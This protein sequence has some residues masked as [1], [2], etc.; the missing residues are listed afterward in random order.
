[1]VVS[2]LGVKIYR[3]EFKDSNRCK[4]RGGGIDLMLR[5]S[6]RGDLLSRSL[7]CWVWFGLRRSI[8]D[9]FVCERELHGSEIVH[10]EAEH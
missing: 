1:M 9:N 7:I 5:D 3:A 4:I 6:R 2:A 8:D 10:V